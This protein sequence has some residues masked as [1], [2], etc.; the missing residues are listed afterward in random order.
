M[1]KEND[2]IVRPIDTFLTRYIGYLG[3]NKLIP[4]EQE[5]YLH[6]YEEGIL[7]Q[8]RKI[9][10]TQIEIPY[11]SVTEVL[12]VDGGNKTELDRVL[13]FGILGGMWKKQ[14]ILTIIKYKDKSFPDKEQVIVF[15]F[16][17]GLQKVQPLIYEKMQKAR[18]NRKS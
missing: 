6:V 9:K 13:A 8:F 16:E 14:H 1:P 4:T 2:G 3:T 5:I 17:K 11:T 18:T 7:I 12:N 10:R 15:D